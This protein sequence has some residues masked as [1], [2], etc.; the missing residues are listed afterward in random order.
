M[1]CEDHLG[2]CLVVL[3]YVIVWKFLFSVFPAKYLFSIF[4]S[5]E[6][7]RFCLKYI[8][9][10]FWQISKNKR[11]QDRAAALEVWDRLEEFVRSR[12]HS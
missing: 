12:S 6:L 11:H 2:G 8:L 4:L 9:L 1:E 3:I 7:L 5:F 10:T